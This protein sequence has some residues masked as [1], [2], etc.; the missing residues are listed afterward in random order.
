MHI[1]FNYIHDSWYF[2]LCATVP[3]TMTNINNNLA[4]FYKIYVDDVLVFSSENTSNYLL[5]C[6]AYYIGGYHRH[7]GFIIKDSVEYA[8]G[9]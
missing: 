5:N 8:L 4:C 6:D 7:R 9:T 2:S 1:T 3:S